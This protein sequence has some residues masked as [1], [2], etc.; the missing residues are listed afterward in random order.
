VRR[1]LPALVAG[2]LA[3]AALAGCGSG[4]DDEAA[5]GATAAA[6][7]GV[8]LVEVGSF[9]EPVY[10]TAPVGDDRVFVV[11]R[12]GRIRV[13]R[14][15]RKLAASFLDLSG[16]TQAGGER[17]LLSM[18]FAPDYATSGRFYVDYTDL[19]G[20]TR[21]VEYRVDPANPDRADPASAREVLAQAQPEPNHNGGLLLFGPDDLLYVGLGDG[22]GGGDRHGPRG[23][24]QDLGTWL[25]KILRIDPRASGGRPYTVPASNPF[26][27]RAGARPEVY[28]YGL[29]NPWRFSFDRASGAIAI[30]D[31]GQE[32]VEEVSFRRSGRARGANFGWRVFEGSRRYTAGE[33]AP[34]AIAPVIERLHSKGN[35][36]ITGGVVVRDPAL[37]SLAG[38]Y[39]FADFCDGRILSARLGERRAAGL[40]S[41][42]LRVDG[43]SSF[44]EDAR[45]RVYVTSLG[46]RVFRLAAR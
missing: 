34:G 2:V 40:R 44:G 26:V 32:E 10:V 31:V 9:A 25:G 19:R 24:A 7:G 45:G 15:G 46:G 13:V 8:R 43:P 6:A 22:G 18:A 23:N 28:A 30:A 41:T 35:C 1:V 14:G 3:V 33:R 38:R 39:V 4:G 12:G 5:P 27:R 11:E 20:D 42:G 36:S 21:V 17:G 37:R 16:K 29:R